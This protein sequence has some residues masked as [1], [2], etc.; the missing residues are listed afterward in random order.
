[1]R[2]EKLYL[3]KYISELISGADYIYFVSYQGLT[4]KQFSDLRLK[5]SAVGG[6]C[7]V[8]KNTMIRKAAEL[9]GCDELA[10]T[11]L[12]DTTAMI[13]GKGDAS[14]VA[15]I[16]IDFSKA[17][18]Q[19]AAKGGYLE[20][21]LLSVSDFDAIAALPS[22]EVLRAQLL[23][24]LQGPSRNLVSLLNAKAASILNV[25]NAYKEKL[26]D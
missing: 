2:S 8:L 3:A 11:E 1:M 25:L 13:C 18:T 19:M 10:K 26:E 4:V 23:G 5:L 24:V 14:A 6:E 16:I 12:K 22:K 17:N 15:K 20:G 21:A 7:H 9:A